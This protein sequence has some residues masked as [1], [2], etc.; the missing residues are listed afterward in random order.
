MGIRRETVR[1]VIFLA[2]MLGLVTGPAAAST[3]AVPPVPRLIFPVVGPSTYFDDFGAPRGS[4]SHDG[5][6]IMAPKRALAV[7][8]E[9]GTVKFG[10]SSSRAGCMLYL[11]GDSGTTY[12]YIHL[13]NDRKGDDA[14]GC[15]SGVTFPV[16]L[17]SGQRV[18]AGQPIGYVGDSGDAEGAGPHLHFEVHPGGKGAV[19]PFKYL[20]AARK[21]LFAAKP[22]SLVT[23]SLRG[24]VTDAFDGA[25][26]V[27][28]DHLR[29][30][31]G[32]LTVPKVDRTVELS[33]PPEVAV[34]NPV[35][36]LIAGAKL[37]QAAVGKAAVVWTHPQEATLEA[38]LGLPGWLEAERI[39]LQS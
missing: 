5:N 13:N 27:K 21:L 26:E 16:G 35:G 18:E 6:D 38:Q 11:H 19:S 24:T 20:R 28:V 39:A 14:A 34:F 2:A 3:D 23:L 12:L 25:V 10:T 30:Y 1:G 7:A 36:A 29:R 8:V 17:K 32:G 9:P 33:V 15:L 31:P 4:G 22:G 37:A